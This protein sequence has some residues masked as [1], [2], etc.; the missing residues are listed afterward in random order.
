MASPAVRRITE[1]GD[2]VW[3]EVQR[4][5][6]QMQRSVRELA[7]LTE[8]VDEEV[9]L[10]FSKSNGGT[11]K[12]KH[13]V[14]ETVWILQRMGLLRSGQEAEIIRLSTKIAAGLREELAP[15]EMTPDEKKFVELVD[16]LP[17]W[18]EN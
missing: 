9:A 16:E 4:A 6:D 13:I 5:M 2:Q 17:D 7:G 1:V 14:N 12:R 8:Q 11:P 10:Y 18:K 15:G 3:P